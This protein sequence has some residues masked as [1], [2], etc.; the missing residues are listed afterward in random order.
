[1][2]Q[3][4]VASAHIPAATGAGPGVH[5]S[6]RFR[7]VP[8][9]T[10]VVP[11]ERNP[12]WN[13]TLVWPLGARPLRP[14][15]SLALRLRHWGQPAPQGELGA[16]TVP[17]GRL[18]EEPGLP[19]ALSHLPLLDPR[20]RPTGATVTV[21]CSYI[22]PGQ[23]AAGD[24]APHQQ[25]RVA[26]CLSPPCLSPAVGTAVG[27]PPGPPH[28]HAKPVMERK[29]DFQVRVRV[30]EGH[31]LQGNDIK[32][33]VTVLI[34][35]HRFRTRIRA[36]NNP[37]YNEVFSQHFH[38]TPVQLAAVPIHVQV[39]NSRAIRA[40]ATI[41]AFKLDVSTVYNA[42]GRRLSWKWL[43]LQHP[44]RPEAGSCGYL[45]VSLA[46]LRAGEPVA[47]PEEPAGSEEV[48]ANLLQPSPLT[49]CVATLQ[50]RVYRAEDL[51]Q[52]EPTRPYLPAVLPA[53]GKR[54]FV[55]A[56]VRASFAGR[57]LCT[58]VM[59]PDANPAWNEV[60][61]FPLRLPPVCD[62]IELAIVSGSRAKVLG[63]A[64]LH[65]SQISSAGAELQ[66]GVSGF[67]PCFGPSFLPFY[68]PRPDPARRPSTPSDTR[69]A[70]RGRV[71]LELSTHT[72]SPDGRQQDTIAPEDVARVQRLLPRRRRFGLCGVFYSATML[73]PAPELLRFELSIGNY[74]DTGD[75]TCRPAASATP[76]GHPLFD[77]NRYHYLP[78]YDAKPVVA[79]TSIWEDAGYRWD[80]TNLLQNM[81]QR[82]EGNV[83]ALRDAGTATCGDAGRRLL[84]ELARDCRVA[85]PVLEAQLPKTPLDTELRAAR[86]HLLRLMAA[87]A[88]AGPPR[89]GWAALLPEAEAWLGR[90][91]ALAAEASG[92]IHAQLRV[93]LWLGRVAES[94]DLPRC[95]EGTLRIYAE[96]YENQTKLLGK[97]SGRGLPGRPS[98]SD[99][100]GKAGLPRHRIRPPKGW[101]WDGP[102]AVEPQRR[103]LLDT[104]ANLGE[105]LEEVYENESRQPGGDWGPAAMA[106]TDAVGAAVP[107][108]EEVACPQ[109]WHVTDGWRVDVAGAVDEAG[110]EYGA[111]A[112]PGSPPLA[113]H[114]AEKTY[115]T[116]RRRRW[117]R[118]RRREPGAQGQEQ[119]VATFLQL[120][121][122]EAPAADEAW[123][124][125]TLWGCRFHLRP[126][127]GDLCRRRCWHR[128]MV[129]SQSSSVAPIF[130]LEGSPGAEAAVPE[131]EQPAAGTRSQG[132]PQQPMPL[133]LCT[134]QRPSYFQLRCYLFQALELVPH[135]TKATADPVTHVSFVHVSQST[136]VLA[137]TL[138]PR[139]DQA[140]LFHRVLLYGDPRGVR[141]EPPAVVV[142]VFDQE[143]EGAGSFLG[144]C[145]CTPHVW[146]DLGRRQPP[147]LRRY[148]LEGPGGP[149]GELLAAFE[150]LHEAEEGAL[151]QL[152]TP[153]WRDGTFSVPLGIRPLLRL[154][155]LEVLAWGLR[156]LRGR[157]P[158]PVRA[159][160]LEVQC[161]GQVLRTPPIADLAAN[162]NFPINAFLLPLVRVR[163]RGAAHPWV[164]PAAPGVTA[165]F[166]PSTCRRRRSTCPPS[167]CGCWTR[168]GSGT[169]PRWGRRACGAWGASAASPTV[170]GGCLDPVPP[171]R[172]LALV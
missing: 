150:L 16:T 165:R 111:S 40:E 97:W 93:R 78:W 38:L 160:C 51:P 12:T 21:R 144:R 155:A 83:A 121:S 67:L 26:P 47:E 27:V 68:G 162:P 164:L 115:H 139:W 102:W 22:P 128:R 107:P 100:T 169:G 39:L 56:A 77:G 24:T 60:L 94:R 28:H 63:T 90:V 132:R 166:G 61:F 101:R 142:E 15:A 5:V 41:G 72:G 135:G 172:A 48:E 152:S 81:A 167:G 170:G 98:F 64:T 123:E 32:P 109:G 125:A 99:I 138:D 112:A 17:L 6:A 158:L 117:L 18:A 131:G 149:A 114:P 42:P 103:L 49:P 37:Y 57:T 147:R 126:R 79:V 58:R 9:S 130:L 96:T 44:R 2:L 92:H 36:G 161:G 95:L 20:G 66:G 88:T 145:V 151:A 69:V 137:R 59:P 80:A 141:D 106:N 30:I 133:I 113:W 29:E 75:P 159:P 171:Q 120:H 76:H 53:G 13:E 143:G 1:M 127:A 156:G 10:R 3:L 43:S 8:R 52:E 118:T 153:P 70:Y 129:P 11:A 25:G 33:V 65:L 146:L 71:L 46:V 108:K 7:G 4:L 31:Q 163:G 84:R 140:L 34:G 23:V 134:F 168:R 154:V 136:R 73:A 14:S 19:L 104:E 82:L 74:G 91:A 89:G 50:L 122:P 54:G 148:P 35:E 85:L 62:A 87:A 116:H 119:D 86:L 110:W 105:V 45:R 157:S 124:Y 55:A